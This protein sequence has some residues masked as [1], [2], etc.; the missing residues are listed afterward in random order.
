[1]AG[2]SCAL[3]ICPNS[4]T[5]HALFNDSDSDIAAIRQALQYS[6]RSLNFCMYE[7]CSCLLHAAKCTDYSALILNLQLR[8]SIN[9]AVEP[10]Y[11]MMV[12][13]DMVIYKAFEG[14]DIH[15]IG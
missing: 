9:T 10:S 2:T 13:V 4:Q 5:Q 3:N 1:M 14:T 11:L 6:L 8:Y 12:E 15:G 7:A